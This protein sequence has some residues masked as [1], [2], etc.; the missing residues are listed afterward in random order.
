M[1]HW[2]TRYLREQRL[3][4][5]YAATID[6]VLLPLG[7]QLAGRVR[8]SDSLVVIGLCGAQGSGKSTAAAVLCELLNEQELPAVAVSI[9]DFYLP[10]AQREELAREVHPL[11]ITRGVPG[12]HDVELAQAVIES[13][14]E[15][16]T[17][18]VP[19]FDKATDDRRPRQQW[20]EVEGPL[21]VVILE[22]WCVGARPQTAAQ[23]ATPINALERDEDADGRWRGYVNAALQGPYAT[24]FARLSPMVLLQAPSFEVVLRWRTE[25]EHKL[26]ER[27]QQEGG[28]ATRVMSDAQIARFISHYER[29]TR[30]ILAQMPAR[31]EHLIA[32]DASRRAQWLR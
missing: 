24:L 27:L 10:R 25:Q 2:I 31:A 23:L 7:E 28:D 12:T 26:R 5:S 6:E 18:R 20:R 8:L 29:I 9:D 17:T 4:E 3:P 16:G 14:A 11:L 15:G 32:L 19:V 30:Q 13:L 21:R 1:R 22:G